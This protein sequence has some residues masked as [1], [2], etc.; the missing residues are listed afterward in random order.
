MLV[1]RLLVALVIVCGYGFAQEPEIGKA[2]IP[3]NGIG[4]VTYEIDWD[5]DPNECQSKMYEWAVEGKLKCVGR[6]IQDSGIPLLEP[7]LRGAIMENQR[8]FH[9]GAQ[10]MYR[11]QA[12][13]YLTQPW[14]DFKNAES[15]V[16]VLSQVMQ[17]MQDVAR[18]ICE[19]GDTEY[20]GPSV[21]CI[22]TETARGLMAKALTRDNGSEDKE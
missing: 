2:T 7:G 10:N 19:A 22:K 21:G 20:D 6:V 1:L 15:Q 18:V 11:L 5:V 4:P 16:K 3:F 8:D 14:I 12:V 17:K 9:V 13:A